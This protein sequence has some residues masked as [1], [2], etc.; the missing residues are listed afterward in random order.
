MALKTYALTTLAR[1][2]SFA[3]IS[4]TTYDTLLTILIN[5]VTEIIERYCNRRFKQTTYTNEL[6]DS[7]GGEALFVKNIPVISSS[8]ITLQE[9]N[10][11]E[12]ED[13]WETVDA[14]DYYVDYDSGIIY[15]IGA[16]NW[17][18]G[19]QRYRITYTAGYNFDNSSTYLEDTV[20]ADVE[21]ACWKLV[22]NVFNKRG[23]V[24][25]IKSE[26][27]GDYS[28][29]YGDVVTDMPDDVR[30]ILDGYKIQTNVAGS[31]NSVLVV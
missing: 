23:Q 18:A 31:P 20:A 25:N 6:L 30:N 10:S 17:L 8:T 12:N 24:S 29:T 27:L 28:V 1:Y 2:K 13:D 15:K 19:R 5:S 21:L 7:D 9:R 4:N 11:D 26:S 3:K 16:G 14:E 22:D